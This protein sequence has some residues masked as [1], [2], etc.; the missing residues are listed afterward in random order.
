M[1]AWLMSGFATG[2]DY[3][4]AGL[5]HLVEAAKAAQHD[6]ECKQASQECQCWGGLWKADTVVMLDQVSDILT[7]AY[8]Q[9][10]QSQIEHALAEVLWLRK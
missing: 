1:A 4:E 5:N 6:P 2:D 10:N 8:L 7:E 3:A 9:K